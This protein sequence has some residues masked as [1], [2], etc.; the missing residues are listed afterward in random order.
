MVAG[1]QG[2]V[3]TCRNGGWTQMHTGTATHLTG[4]HADGDGTV[5][6]TGG[7]FNVRRN[8]FVGTLLRLRDGTWATLDSDEPLP[9][10]RAVERIGD[11]VL[12]VGDHGTVARVEGDRIVT[13]RVDTRRDLYG[14]AAAGARNAACAWATAES[15]SSRGPRSRPPPCPR[16]RGRCRARRPREP[17]G[18]GGRMPDGPGALVGVGRR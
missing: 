13:E 10:L 4:L 8:G 15:R 16:I 1:A 9:R 3:L 14:L 11:A 6:A 7:Q 18:G 12:A 5:Y 2:T 17:V